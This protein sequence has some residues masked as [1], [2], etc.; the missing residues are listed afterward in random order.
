MKSNK[1]KQKC[2]AQSVSK[3]NLKTKRIG[4]YSEKH[5]E[6]LRQCKK[7]KTV[8]FLCLDFLGVLQFRSSYGRVATG[9][10]YSRACYGAYVNFVT[11]V[12]KS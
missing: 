5:I 10:L 1:N 9:T 2:T 8:L 11:V 7:Q 6:Q 4:N 12:T 3:T